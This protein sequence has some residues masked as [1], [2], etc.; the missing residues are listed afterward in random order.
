MA[1]YWFIA[2]VWSSLPCTRNTGILISSARN[3]GDHFASIAASLPWMRSLTRIRRLLPP[4]IQSL[5]II[6]MS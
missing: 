5:R 4:S 1:L 3:A 6:A 2:A